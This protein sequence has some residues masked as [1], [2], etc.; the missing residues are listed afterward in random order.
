MN[1]GDSLLDN[2]EACAEYLKAVGQSIEDFEKECFQNT[3]DRIKMMREPADEIPD[4][5][6]EKWS[7]PIG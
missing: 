4:S 7:L 3:I 1:D 2:K 5:L 6:K